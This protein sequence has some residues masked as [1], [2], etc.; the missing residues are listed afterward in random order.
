VKP[1]NILTAPVEYDE[2]DPPGYHAGMN[3]FGREL[4]ASMM[5]G[6]VY[7]LPP[8]ESICPYHYEYGNEEWLIV[9]EGP[10]ALRHPQGEEKLGRGDVVCFPVGAEGAHKVT[11]RGEATA[12]VLMVSTVFE[13]AVAIYPDSDKLGV[14]PGDT[15]DNLLTRRSSAVDYWDGES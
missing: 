3:R 12:R 14:W 11:N 8:G 10:V 4:A 5:G 9:L 1:F 15:R 13:P 7:E 2:N 6:S